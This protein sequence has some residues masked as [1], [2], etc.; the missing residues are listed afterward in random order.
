MEALEDSGQDIRFKK[1][2]CTLSNLENALKQQPDVLQFCGH[3]NIQ[4]GME[5]VLEQSGLVDDFSIKRFKTLSWQP[6]NIKI[7][8]LMSCHSQ[9]M[10]QAFSDAGVNHVICVQQSRKIDD[11]AAVFFTKAF[12]DNA[13]VNGMTLCQAFFD[14]KSKTNAHPDFDSEGDAIMILRELDKNRQVHKRDKCAR[15]RPNREGKL[16]NL[17]SKHSV[18]F[19]IDSIIDDQLTDKKM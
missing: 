10:G 17:D 5:M 9:K 6:V 3:G 13:F 15:L 1:A 8:I 11:A 12:Y 19:R 14:A 18:L 7:I 16:Q 2:N 4:E